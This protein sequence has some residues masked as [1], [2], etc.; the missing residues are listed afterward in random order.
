MS[1]DAIVFAGLMPHAP[2]LVAGVGRDHHAHVQH[3]I[4]AMTTV[5]RHAVAT[6]PDTIL[7]ISPH[8]PRH[9]GAFGI[10]Q[11]PLLHG[12]FE[13]FGAEEN[14]VDLPLDHDFA[15]RLAKVASAHGLNT[16]RI[17]SGA[18]DY[19]A[20]VP[21]SY[22]I[23]AGW[24][25]PT[26][27]VGLNDAG[28]GGLD[29]LGIAIAETAAAL[30]RR[31]AVIASGDM[32][33][34]L[35]ASAPCGFHADGTRFDRTFIDFLRTG[36]PRDI[37]R[38]DQSLLDHAAEDVVDA[39][40]VALATTDYATPGR[41]VLSYEGPFGVGYGVAILAERPGNTTATTSDTDASATVLSHP[42]DLPRVA[43]SAVLAEVNGHP[44]AP[45]F[46]AAGEL[47]HPQAIFVTVRARN[48]VLRGCRGSAMPSGRDLV[49]ETWLCAQE[50]A[51]HDPRFPPL[52]VMDLPNV[53][54]SVSILSSLEPVA[55]IADLNPLFYGV[56]V[57]AADGRKGLLLP[58][59]K[60]VDSAVEQ[61]RLA[62]H[63][64]GI[65]LDESV[66]IQRFTTQVF[67]EPL[68]AEEGG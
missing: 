25:G 34:R 38:L 9:S 1:S 42:A 52:R 46:Q 49:A 3:T 6:Q 8:S 12:S 5:A 26:V 64:A 32:S 40:H 17:T 51:F 4:R 20:T 67:Q 56:L 18:L 55:S 60:G 2:I 16:W 7:L 35:T 28:P 65:R 57:S 10:W 19:G 27:V 13:Q 33:H 50:A 54:L 53:R 68:R 45:P 43:R 39:T 14:R 24:K 31:L 62:K 22:L 48:D 44:D 63:K 30:E 66:T 15:D 59:I 23:A 47:K 37:T 29:D 11:T 21:L 58:A 61:V 36:T 41:S